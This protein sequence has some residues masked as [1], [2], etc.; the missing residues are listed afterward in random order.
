M[1][2]CSAFARGGGAS[3]TA[4]AAG[5]LLTRQPPSRRY[6]ALTVGGHIFGILLNIG[7][8]ALLI[9]M[10]RRANTLEAGNGEQRIVE[11]RERRMTL[12]VM[13]GFACIALWSPLGLALN[14]LLASVSDLAWIDVAPYGFASALGFMALG[15]AFDRFEF[16]RPTRPRAI[17]DDPKG[18]PALFKLIGHIGALSG[19]AML[20][21]MVTNRP[22]QAILVNLVPVYATLWLTGIAVSGKKGGVFG[23]TLQ[24]LRDN[25]VARWPNYA[26]EIS[27]FAASGFLGVVLAALAPRQAL[28]AAFA[29]ASL[30][31]GVIAAGLA[32]A[33]VALGFIGLNPMISASILAATLDSISVPGLSHAHAVLAL[34]LGWTCVIGTAPLMSS[35]VMASSL[36]GRSSSEVGLAWNGRFTIAA[37]WRRRSGRAVHS[38]V[39]PLREAIVQHHHIALDRPGAERNAA[40][41]RQISVRMVSPG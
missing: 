20:A 32:C 22:F 10:T 38:A 39:I 21:E 33:V 31:P 41:S 7:G 11:L 27:I 30:P 9:D 17:V 6:L 2:P 24:H 3:D 19:L 1:S 25:G 40:S 12:A 35:L 18:L 13:R 29:A 15:F 8:L 37:S 34:A 36:I 5:A 14:L 4:T 23:F 28:Q 16:P 26:N